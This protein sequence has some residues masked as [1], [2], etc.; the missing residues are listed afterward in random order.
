M[1]RRLLSVPALAALLAA[2][3]HSQPSSAQAEFAVSS[4]RPTAPGRQNQL[5]LDYCRSDG[6]FA[7]AGAPVLWSLKYAFDLPEYEIADAPQ[8]L[9]DFDS[10]YDIAAKPDTAVDN[11]QCRALL[12]SLFTERFHLVTHHEE[13]IT[14]VYFLRPAK[15]GP[16]LRPGGGVHLNGSV[17]VNDDGKPEWPDGWSMSR[18]ARFLSDMVER[19]V[20]DQTGL[21]G[22]YGI[23]LE[24]SRGDNDDRPD[25][26]TAISD[27]LGLRLT[28]GKAPVDMLV[29][30]HIQRPDPN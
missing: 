11:G 9:S 12:R 23:A 6:S 21:P 19:P 15:T 20:I 28:S 10:A 5:R 8:W 29:I 7:M 16:K 30:D 25:I 3:L 27:Q 26:R 1:L 14:S 24:W 17:Q 2:G 4:V 22:T 13:R 18:L